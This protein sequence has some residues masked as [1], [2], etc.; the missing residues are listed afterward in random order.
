MDNKQASIRL[1]DEHARK[2]LEIGVPP[3][4]KLAGAMKAVARLDEVIHRLTG[5]PCLS[6]IDVRFRNHIEE[7]IEFG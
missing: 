1:V 7:N 5:C 6:G 3:G 4:G 2:V